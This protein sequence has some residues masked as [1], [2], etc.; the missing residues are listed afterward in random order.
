ITLECLNRAVQTTVRGLHPAR[1]GFRLASSVH[2]LVEKVKQ[3]EHFSI[4]CDES[5]DTDFKIMEE[6]MGCYSANND[7]DRLLF[8]KASPTLLISM[9][10]Q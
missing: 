10:L 2:Q 6:L 9:V 8:L 7:I 5:I 1:H 3:F 4:A